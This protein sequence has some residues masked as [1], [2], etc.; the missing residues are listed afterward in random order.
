MEHAKAPPTLIARLRPGRFGR[1]QPGEG[2]VVEGPGAVGLPSDVPAGLVSVR[3]VF[4]RAQVPHRFHV[5]QAAF[6]PGRVVVGVAAGPRGGAARVSTGAAVAEREGEFLKCCGQPAGA[7]EPQDGAVGFLNGG[8]DVGPCV[9]DQREGVFGREGAGAEDLAL[10]RFGLHGDDQRGPRRSTSGCSQYDGNKR[11]GESALAGFV[12]VSAE[13]F[14]PL[15]M[16]GSP[17]RVAR[18]VQCGPDLFAFDGGK[19]HAHAR[20]S[21]DRP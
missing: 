15:R 13:C 18:F 3:V 19:D 9:V 2:V 6:V 17:C 1:P 5:G 11:V 10:E 14:G 20:Q 7:S 12:V 8:I 4:V 21:R 16:G